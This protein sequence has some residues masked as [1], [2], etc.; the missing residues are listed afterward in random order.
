MQ[1][2]IQEVLN[3]VHI[4]VLKYNQS[5]YEVLNKTSYKEYHIF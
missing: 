5:S 4:F 2:I 1:T 3:N